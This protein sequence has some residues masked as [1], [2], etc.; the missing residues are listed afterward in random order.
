MNS[1]KPKLSESFNEQLTPLNFDD[2]AYTKRLDT[3]P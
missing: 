3:S 1:N 2:K